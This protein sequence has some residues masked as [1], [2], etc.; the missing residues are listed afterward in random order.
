[1]AMPELPP[2]ATLRGL[3]V[4]RVSVGAAIAQAAH[5]FTRRL[6]RA[7]LSDDGAPALFEGRAAYAELNALYTF[8]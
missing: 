8:A 2:L 3:G 7:F 5:G 1:M 6:V 4:R